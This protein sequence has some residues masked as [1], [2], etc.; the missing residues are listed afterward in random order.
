M[1]IILDT[2]VIHKDYTLTG[3]AILKLSDA[4]QKLGYEVYIP[5][6]VVDEIFRQYRTELES[7]YDKYTKGASLLSGL[8]L[9]EIKLEDA[10]GQ[11]NDM[12]DG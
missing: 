10:R 9:K 1:K 12:N 11:V 4:A 7:A 3:S 8:G 5:E 2:N 6:I